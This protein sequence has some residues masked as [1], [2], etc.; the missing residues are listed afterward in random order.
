[1]DTLTTK[2]VV[3]LEAAFA[4][5][6]T[7][8]I[9]L[10]NPIENFATEGLSTVDALEQEILTGNLLIGDLTGAAFTGFKE[11]RTKTTITT[12]YGRDET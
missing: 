8:T 12:T 4:D 9:S 5:G 6:D 11:V 3:E 10:D 2:K 7:R 1:M